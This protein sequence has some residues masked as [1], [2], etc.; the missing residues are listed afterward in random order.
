M[1]TNLN[2]NYCHL[3]YP[4]GYKTNGSGKVN[5]YGMTYNPNAGGNFGS[6]P[7]RTVL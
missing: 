5:I 3:Y 7:V 4:K 1:L 2:C 6:G